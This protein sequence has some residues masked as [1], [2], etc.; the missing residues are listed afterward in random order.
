MA[1]VLSRVAMWVNRVWR[2]TYSDPLLPS[3]PGAN[4]GTTPAFPE[5]IDLDFPNF[6]DF[7]ALYTNPVSKTYSSDT[8]DQ[9]FA[10][11]A[12][13]PAETQHALGRIESE[14]ERMSHLVEDLLLLARLDSGPALRLEELDLT[15]IVVNAVSDAQAA[16]P[17]HDWSVGLPVDGSPV[18][19]LG[20]RYRLHQVVANL[21]AN[22][23]T[24]TPEGTSVETSLAVEQGRAGIRVTDNGPGIEASIAQRVFERFMR[25]DVARVRS[26]KGTSS[27]GLGLAIVEAVVTA[28]GGTA[29]VASHPGQTT[30]TISL[31]LAP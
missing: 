1:W 22:A 30:F 14:S 8:I 29:S 31:P 17:G 5:S 23:R 20:D 15:D 21:L 25:A 4:G 11:P 28:H 18:V 3:S 24:H 9:N 27:T 19:A 2:V 6:N 26:G 7:F 16:G 12:S 13:L 10:I